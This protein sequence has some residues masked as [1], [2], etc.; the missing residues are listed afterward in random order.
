MSSTVWFSDGAVLTYNRKSYALAASLPSEGILTVDAKTVTINGL[1]TTAE[2]AEE[3]VFPLDR[4]VV[5][6]DIE[7]AIGAAGVEGTLAPSFHAIGD[8]AAPFL[9][10]VHVAEAESAAEAA[11]SLIGTT[12]IDGMKT[13][14]QPLLASQV[15][16]GAKPRISGPLV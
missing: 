16:L 8:H 13:G 14:V 3:D 10:V 2:D 15:Q 1:I 4:A 12:I 11:A 7:S 5:M 9:V 6:G